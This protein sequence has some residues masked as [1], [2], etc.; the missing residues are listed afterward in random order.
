LEN[1]IDSVD[2]FRL[3]VC[4]KVSG[5]INLIRNTSNKEIISILKNKIEYEFNELYK[6]IDA[7]KWRNK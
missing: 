4:W 2:E 1:K 3:E 6:F 7:E 5:Y